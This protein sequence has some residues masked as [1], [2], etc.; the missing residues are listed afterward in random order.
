MKVSNGNWWQKIT[1]ATEK[2]IASHALHSIATTTHII[3]QNGIP[4]VIRIIDNLIRKEKQ[5]KKNK[6]DPNFN[7]FLPFETN[8]FIGEISTTHVAILNKF[9]VVNNHLLIITRD[10]EAQENI[11]NY[12]DFFALW[13]I[14]VE[15]D[16]FAFYN[17]GA[18]A[19]A[20]QAHKHLQLIPYASGK[21]ETVPIEELILKHSKKE[22]II[23]LS[24]LPFI[25]KIA[26]FPDLDNKSID[27][28]AKITLDY[29]HQLL[30]ELNIKIEEQ[31]PSLQYNFL[32]TKKWMMIV[33]RSQ[34][35]FDKISVNSLGFCGALLAK[36]QKGLDKIKQ[37]QP[38][39]I[40]KQVGFK[41]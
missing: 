24:E 39:E 38:L 14:L 15:V 9:N 32:M 1:Q 31:K 6:K 7:P 37:H 40:L 25:H 30:T 4:F 26:F 35:K 19:G 21:I 11:L 20:S 2:A 33:P 41:K 8:L 27:E 23:S 5:Q 3:E 22:E 13:S 17:A 16:G 28:L 36:N 18:I 34:D 12:D 29:Y 10:F